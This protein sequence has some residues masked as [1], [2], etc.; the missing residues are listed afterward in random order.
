MLLHLRFAMDQLELDPVH[1]PLGHDLG[2]LD[3]LELDPR[4]AIGLPQPVDRD[5]L[6]WVLPME[7]DAPLLKREANPFV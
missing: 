6:V 2:G 1:L 3:L 4:L 5:P 7:H